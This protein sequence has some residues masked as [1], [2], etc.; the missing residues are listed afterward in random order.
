MRVTHVNVT[1]LFGIFNHPIDFKLDDRIT[2]IHG[3]NGYGKTIVLKMIEGILSGSYAIFSK[4]PFSSFELHFDDQSKVIVRRDLSLLHN[5]EKSSKDGGT[6]QQR[7]RERERAKAIT[8]IFVD[9]QGTEHPVKLIERQL[10]SKQ[11]F[12]LDRRLPSWVRNVGNSWIDERKNKV[13]SDEQVLEEY[14]GYL[15]SRASEVLTALKLDDNSLLRKIQ[16]RIHVHLIGTER[17]EKQSVGVPDEEVVYAFGRQMPQRESTTVEQYSQDLISRIASLLAL[18]AGRASELDRTFPS[19][20][21]AEMQIQPYETV[22]LRERLKAIEHQRSVLMD[23]DILDEKGGLSQIPDELYEKAA[24]VLTVYVRDTEEK[25]GTFN[26]IAAKISLFTKIINERFTHKR[27]RISREK[28]FVFE[29]TLGDLPPVALS[30]GEQ[31]EVVL[32]YELLFKVDKSW[33]VML[34]EPEI[35]LHVGWQERFLDDLMDI[36]KLS[37]V[38]V[39]IATHSPVVIGE[40]WDLAI[41]LKAPKGQG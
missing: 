26:E 1:G 41:A 29:A 3:P 39:L 24:E 30:S 32:L 10:N 38:D 13:F 18:Y 19:R 11:R 20:L 2:I 5:S 31:H 16:N 7:K 23:L 6:I 34:D 9:A 33:L 4:V 14:E 21:L 27:L 12:E 8:A 36:V 22:G 40:H 37:N 17:L 35:S 25:L 15:R 28:G